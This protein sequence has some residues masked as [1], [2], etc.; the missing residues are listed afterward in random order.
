MNKNNQNKYTGFR[1]NYSK[2]IYEDFSIVDNP[3]EIAVKY[4][5]SV[6]DRHKFTPSFSISK[7]GNSWSTYDKDFLENLVFQIGLVEL[8]SYWKAICPKAVII[9]AGKLDESQIEFW[10]KLY[11][12]GLGE[13][14]YL[15]GIEADFDNFMVLYPESEREFKK[16]FTETTNQQVIVPIG[17]GKD[18]AVTLEL[19]KEKMSV[20][21]FIVNPR[22]AS[23]D[24]VK[25]AGFDSNKTFEIQRTID[26]HLI[27][28]NNEG[29]LNG[30]TPFSALLAFMTVLAAVITN[31]KF[32]ALSNES[33]ANEP[34]V[35]T[36]ANHQYSKSFEFELDFR[37]YCKSY[38]S[39]N[40]EYFSF[41]RPLNE[42]GIARLFSGMKKYHGAFRSCNVVS[43]TDSW[44]G[45]CP[46][47]LFTFIMLSP[48]IE[49]EKVN[50]IFGKNLFA[51]ESLIPF[52]DELTG[53]AD[54]KPFECVG[55]IDEVNFALHKTLERYIGPLPALLKYYQEN[56]DGVILKLDRVEHEFDQDHHLVSPF[57]EILISALNDQ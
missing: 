33:S 1:K 53:V 12:N 37:N 31:S 11:F 6:D 10:K 13:F 34:T 48:F 20:I 42:F 26:P 52:L 23:L 57:K 21:P 51:D 39:E 2:F 47:C 40:I 41:L 32:I 30:H 25:I 49:N 46:K 4:F 8:I 36:G 5:F 44:C 45:K 18:S 35:S 27:K 43:K 19:L 7:R 50:R 54:E 9:K 29:F 24:T 17:G 3:Q 22:K 56:L 38:L 15:N 55:T 16:S 14:F 28:L